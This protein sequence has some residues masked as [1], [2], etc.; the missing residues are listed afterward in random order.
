MVRAYICLHACIG[1]DTDNA[2]IKL[3]TCTHSSSDDETCKTQ[4]NT[5]WRTSKTARLRASCLRR[6][7]NSNDAEHFQTLL[8]SVNDL[9]P[10]WAGWAQ[11]RPSLRP[12]V[13]MPRMIIAQATS[14]VPSDETS[15]SDPVCCM[16]SIRS[17]ATRSI[18]KMAY[19]AEALAE[20]LISASVSGCQPVCCD[21]VLAAAAS[22]R[23]VALSNVGRLCPQRPNFLTAETI[24]FVC[25]MKNSSNSWMSSNPEAVAKFQR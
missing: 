7:R 24:G 11:P 1:Q 15:F 21:D 13:V 4:K 12:A 23:A 3:V 20:A 6:T 10:G 22:M 18:S 25:T 17:K 19:A 9:L 5:I 8:S 16:P 14:P 2:L